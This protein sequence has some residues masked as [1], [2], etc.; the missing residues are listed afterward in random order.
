MWLC[1]Y[2]LSLLFHYAM[3]LSFD[4]WRNV[5]HFWLELFLLML[6]ILP[7]IAPPCREFQ[8]E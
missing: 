3:Y 6:N 2:I 1:P 7:A 4:M 8:V 5:C